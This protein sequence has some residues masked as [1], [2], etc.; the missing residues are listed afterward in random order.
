MVKESK[1]FGLKSLERISLK[2]VDYFGKRKW[3]DVFVGLIKEFGSV[4]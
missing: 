1:W 4:I 3:F 2:N